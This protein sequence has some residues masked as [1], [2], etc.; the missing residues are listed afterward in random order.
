MYDDFD[1][2][3]LDRS[4]WLPQYLPAWSSGAASRASY[5]VHDSC[6]DLFIPPEQGLWCADDHQPPLRV[7]GVQSGNY[8][9]PAQSTIGQQPYRA[10]LRVQEEQEPFWGWTPRFGRIEVRARMWLSPRSMAAFFLIGREVAPEQ[11][12]EICVFEVFG[13]AVEEGAAAGVG[14]GLH[15]FR[16][17]DVA[18]DFTTTRVDIDVTEFHSYGVEWTADAVTFDVDGVK[19][20]TCTG[21]PT[22][23]MQAIIAVYDFPDKS[24]GSDGD[25]VP[26]LLVDHVSG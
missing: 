8:S 24:N 4:V 2:S 11:C 22:Y 5:S 15:A 25:H 14:A 19:T 17:P 16:D 6:L 3:Q 20:H 21:A 18:E 7:S 23:P 10:G 13:D 26:R 1:G 12:A 9:G